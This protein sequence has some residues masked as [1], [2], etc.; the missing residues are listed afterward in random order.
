MGEM[1]CKKP[2]LAGRNLQ[3]R[4]ALASVRLAQCLVLTGAPPLQEVNDRNSV[5]WK[6]YRLT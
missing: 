2:Q 4:T 6:Q 5:V 1:V 3:K